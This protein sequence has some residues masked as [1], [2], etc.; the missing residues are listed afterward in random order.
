MSRYGEVVDCSVK[1]DVSTGRSRG[2]GFVM[3]KTQDEADM[4]LKTRPHMLDGK[5]VDRFIIIFKIDP[6][7]AVGISK[8]GMPITK[9]IFVGGVRS[10]TTDDA[11][12]E[13][14]SQ[15]GAV[16]SLDF[17]I[18]HTTSKRRGFCFLEFDEPDAAER[19][20]AVSFHSIGSQTVEVKPAYTKEQ[21]QAL[22]ARGLWP[23]SS[24]SKQGFSLDIGASDPSMQAAFKGLMGPGAKGDLG[25]QMNQMAAAA[26]F[27]Q[28]YFQYAL[29]LSAASNGRLRINHPMRIQTDLL[30]IGLGDHQLED[31]LQEEKVVAKK[32]V[33]KEPE[34][35]DQ[36]PPPNEEGE[37][38][39]EAQVRAPAEGIET[40][41]KA[42]DDVID[43]FP[44]SYQ[45]CIDL[46][47]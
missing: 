7:K 5:I 3:F 24:G 10:E 13:Y 46:Y 27:Y 18:D 45:F 44:N 32:V 35:R 11:L 8:S 1:A 33:E 37:E 38:P 19:A 14:F 28:T 12:K 42:E 16:H 30:T 36:D 20:M 4:V 43:I 29:A 40:Q 31:H 17:P 21:Q 41:L 34:E 47:S 2:F 15:F 9:K 26:L 22:M 25:G 23:P 39:V 6:K